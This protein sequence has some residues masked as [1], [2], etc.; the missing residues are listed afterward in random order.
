VVQVFDPAVQIDEQRFGNTMASTPGVNPL[1]G[2]LAR[3]LIGGIEGAKSDK[4]VTVRIEGELDKQVFGTSSH[5]IF[6]GRVSSEDINSVI[7]AALDAAI[8]EVTTIIDRP[9]AVK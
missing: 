4:T 7:L 5:G 3:L 1:S 8:V 9:V 2:G 6:R